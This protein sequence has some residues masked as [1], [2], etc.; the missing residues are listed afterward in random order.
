[1]TY[2]SHGQG[3]VAGLFVGGG[4]GLAVALGL[5][6]SRNCSHSPDPSICSGLGSMESA[7]LGLLIAVAGT[8]IGGAIGQTTTVT[9][10]PVA[11]SSTHR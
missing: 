7:G 8:V 3:A 4:V 2:T 10:E 6:A 5:N 9:M 1:V 11:T